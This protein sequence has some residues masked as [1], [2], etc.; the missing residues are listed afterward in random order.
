M[1]NYCSK[2]LREQ[3]GK[4]YYVN[5]QPSIMQIKMCVD[6]NTDIYEIDIKEARSNEDTPYWG[7]L[8]PDGKISM[9]FHSKILVE[10]CFTYGTKIEEEA[11]KGKLIQIVINEIGLV[12][13]RHD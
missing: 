11:G 10:V 9:V 5:I 8:Y 13:N 3:D 12:A 4:I 2:R 1:R 7:W 6:S